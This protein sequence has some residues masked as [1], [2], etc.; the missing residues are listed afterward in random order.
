MVSSL[1][2]NS[3]PPQGNHPPAIATPVI[4]GVSGKAAE[5]EILKME[6]YKASANRTECLISWGR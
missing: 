2:Y 6:I 3:E 5:A 1:I 4:E